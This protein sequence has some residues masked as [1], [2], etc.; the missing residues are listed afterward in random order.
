MLYK[1]FFSKI[2]NWKQR[3]AGKSIPLEKFCV[4]R[5]ERYLAQGNFLILPSLELIYLWNYFK[6]LAKNISS[7]HAVYDLIVKELHKFNELKGIFI[8]Y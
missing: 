7:I 6:V 3:F 5:C 8:Y 2:P 4:R 1:F